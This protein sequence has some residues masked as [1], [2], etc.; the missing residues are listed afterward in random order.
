MIVDNFDPIARNAQLVAE[1]TRS[2]DAQFVREAYHKKA[3]DALRPALQGLLDSKNLRKTG[4]KPF[5]DV[6]LDWAFGDDLQPFRELL[7]ATMAEFDAAR[8]SGL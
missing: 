6:I 7:R 3:I 1:A 2:L 8:R 4:F 5:D